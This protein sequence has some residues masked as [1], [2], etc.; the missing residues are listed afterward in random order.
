MLKRQES[1]D[2]M[3][4]A[5]ADPS[6]RDMV[7][8]LARRPAPIS[9]LARPY[10]M[11]MSAVVQHLKVLEAS[12]LVRSEKVGRV[13][14]ARIVP[15]A[16]DTVDRWVGEHQTRLECRLDRLE[17]YLDADARGDKEEIMSQRTVRHATIVIQRSLRHAPARVFSAWA[18]AEERRSWDV[19]GTDWVI[20]SHE[21]DFRVGGREHSRFGPKNDPAYVSEGVFLDIVPDARI[22]T[23]GTMAD[24]DV[25]ITATLCTVE[26][27]LEGRGTRLVL[28]DQSAFFG[29]ES[30]A[31][32]REGWGEILDRLEGYL[33]RP[34][35]RKE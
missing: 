5:L 28:T 23:A 33:E 1:L 16:L 29:P 3:F 21:Q 30:E 34:D 2:R 12:G 24:H 11:S 13:R 15:R 7:R 32:R 19:P 27:S 25:R 8:R 26:L 9:E 18:N 31:D 17:R 35:Q 4:H 20:A 10:A 6:R 22:I 14:T